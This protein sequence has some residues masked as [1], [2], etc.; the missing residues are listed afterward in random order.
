MILVHIG[1]EERSTI[2]LIFNTWY[3]GL[4]QKSLRSITIC[5][6]STEVQTEAFITKV[7]DTGPKFLMFVSQILGLNH[8]V[9]GVLRFVPLS[10]ELRC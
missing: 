8:G 10:T 2:Q 4:T 6:T 1:V 5:I 9:V 7:L 3:S